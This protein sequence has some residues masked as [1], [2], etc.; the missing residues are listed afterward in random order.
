MILGIFQD[1]YICRHV[2]F[3]IVPEGD[4]AGAAEVDKTE[5]SLSG[6]KKRGKV[7]A[8]DHQTRN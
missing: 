4:G 5:R 8:P 3:D 6:E 2:K 1:E 7:A